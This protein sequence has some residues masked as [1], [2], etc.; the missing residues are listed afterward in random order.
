MFSQIEE[1]VGSLVKIANNLK[2]SINT[3]YRKETLVAKLDYANH[4]FSDIEEQLILHEDKIPVG[5]LNFLIKAS[6]EANFN[7]TSIIQSKLNN[8]SKAIQSNQRAKMALVVDVKLG[9]TL[10]PIYDGNPEN[11]ESFIDA[12][13]LFQQTVNTTFEAGTQAQKDAAEQTVVQFVRTR[14][15]SKAR[16]AISANQNLTQ[17]LDAINLHCA[18]KISADSLIAKLKTIKRTDDLNDYCDKVDKLCSQ[19]KSTYV[20][21]NIPQVIAN[22]MATKCGIEALIRGVKNPES[23]IILKAGSFETLNEAVQKVMENDTREIGNANTNPQNAQILTSRVNYSRGRGATNHRTRGNNSRGNYHESRGRYQNFQSNRGNYTNQ[24]GN[25][26]Q[27]GNFRNQRGNWGQRGSTP[28]MFLAQQSG[29][30][31]QPVAPQAV[32]QLPIG[33]PNQFQPQQQ[34]N[35][36]QSNIHPLGVPLGQH[37]L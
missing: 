22:K 27:R 33:Q 16:Q 29:M 5:T 31:Y 37:T 14:L 21:D 34:Q 6:R 10:V 28:N 30:L 2:K 4:L 24:R 13:R 11:L 36:Q 35:T 1:D 25:W 19:L 26:Y 32:Q 15:T 20:K 23:R 3:N 7:I 17:M 12:V 9:T 8:N 18:S